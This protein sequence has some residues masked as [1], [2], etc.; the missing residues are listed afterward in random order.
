LYV[1]GDGAL[2]L[3]N[4]SSATVGEHDERKAPVEDVREHLQ[5]Q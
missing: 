2:V 4:L 5:L 3:E 1:F